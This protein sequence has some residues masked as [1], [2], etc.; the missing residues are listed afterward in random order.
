MRNKLSQYFQVVA[1]GLALS[2]TTN[3]VTNAGAPAGS[4]GGACFAD[5][6]CNAGLSCNAGQTCVAETPVDPCSGIG[7]S[8]HGICSSGV[9][10]CDAGYTGAACADCDIGYVPSGSNCVL[11]GDALNPWDEQSGPI[12]QLPYQ[13]LFRSN[14][15]AGGRVETGS[16]PGQT[17]EWRV[18]E[19]WNG[20]NAL[21]MA[22]P[23]SGEDNNGIA[24][25]RLP[26]TNRRM[27]MRYLL[28]KTADIS[29]S[30]LF[31]FTRY[32]GSV[33]RSVGTSRFNAQGMYYSS[34]SDFPSTTGNLPTPM[35]GV[36]WGQ[37]PFNDPNPEE[38]GGAATQVWMSLEVECNLDTGLYAIF[39]T[40]EGGATR[41]LAGYNIYSPT[42]AVEGGTPEPE[43]AASLVD[44]SH[45]GATGG[46]G[47]F[48]YAET[49]PG[50][51]I[52]ISHFAVGNGYLGPP[53]GFASDGRRPQVSGEPY[54]VGYFGEPSTIQLES[55]DQ[56]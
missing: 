50:A 19:G 56:P 52:W 38:F 31:L 32:D 24:A 9:C 21:Y 23:T 29:D 34:I 42:R 41:L 45:W 30:K 46:P 7:C 14:P 17:L 13:D 12:T 49:A 3:S 5:G 51:A 47:G 33:A 15:V 54:R 18:G 28:K 35:R 16:A 44:G 37:M 2:C 43:P 1:C 55:A 10:I 27:N 36:A 6:T 39:G 11:D 53:A 4:E 48:P 26:G 22:L 20:E 40:R 25:Q 8:G